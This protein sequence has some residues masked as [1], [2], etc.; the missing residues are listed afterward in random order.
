MSERDWSLATAA[1]VIA[2]VCIGFAIGLWGGASNRNHSD[3]N[4]HGAPKPYSGSFTADTF[5]HEHAGSSESYQTICNSPID[6]SQADLCQQWRGANAAQEAASDADWSVVLSVIGVLGLLFTIYLSNKA[7]T[8]ATDATKAAVRSA[9]AAEKAYAAEN[10]PW[11]DVT[12]SDVEEVNLTGPDPLITFTV[13]AKNIGERPAIAKLFSRVARSGPFIAAGPGSIDW[14]INYFANQHALETL[15]FPDRE[16]AVNY[17]RYPGET[18]PS[19]IERENQI[20][21]LNPGKTLPADINLSVP[22]GVLYRAVGT[23][24]WYQTAYVASVHKKEGSAFKIG[25]VLRRGDILLSISPTGAK[26]T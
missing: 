1:G 26:V 6:S 21:D 25:D 2:V 7:T 5:W 9:V 3:P 18:E 13:T 19:L 15:V 8:A 12:I 22:F 14:A 11:M 16:T 4:D 23:N 10:R 24:D 17:Q 20:R